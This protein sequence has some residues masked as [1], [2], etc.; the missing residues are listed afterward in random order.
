MNLTLLLP[1]MYTVHMYMHAS[2]H[3]FLPLTPT[4][5]ALLLE[6]RNQSLYVTLAHTACIR[7]ALTFPVSG[8]PQTASKNHDARCYVRTDRSCS[9]RKLVWM[10]DGVRMFE[11]P[12]RYYGRPLLVQTSI[13][14]ILYVR[15]HVCIY[16]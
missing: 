8:R 10:A 2:L 1:L 5:Y 7:Y 14:C 13:Y 6:V 11:V 4:N 12:T 9:P 3:H 15:L 16:H